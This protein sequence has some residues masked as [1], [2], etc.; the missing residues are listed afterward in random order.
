MFYENDKQESN[1]KIKPMQKSVIFAVVDRKIKTQKNKIEKMRFFEGNSL[2][3]FAKNMPFFALE[4]RNC[5]ID[6]LSLSNIY[7][8]T[9]YSR[10]NLFFSAVRVCYIRA[11]LYLFVE[12]KKF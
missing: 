6:S 3:F 10:K 5:L 9:F 7:L 2:V 4:K 12:N 8:Y 1:K 11:Y